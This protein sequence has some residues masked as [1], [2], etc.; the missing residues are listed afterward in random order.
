LAEVTPRNGGK[1]VANQH[2]RNRH[3]EASPQRACLEKRNLLSGGT[4]SAGLQNTQV[5][6]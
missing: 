6:K 4:K 1:T 3:F 2:I 5:L